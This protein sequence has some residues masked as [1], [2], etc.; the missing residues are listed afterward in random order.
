MAAALAW[1]VLT[2]TPERP[3]AAIDGD[4]FTSQAWRVQL[5]APKNWELT[6][7][8][9][10]PNVLLRMVRHD[11]L[12]RMLLTAERLA[13][14]QDTPS[15]AESTR[16]LLQ[17]LGFAVRPAQLHA[18]TGA[19]WYDF[20]NGTA[21]LR[22]AVLVQNGTGYSL[23]LAAPDARMRGQHLRA[24]DYALRSLRVSRTNVEAPDAGAASSV[25]SD[26]PSS[27][28]EEPAATQ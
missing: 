14:E 4:T 10:Y 17:S 20:D 18:S 27:A 2:L 6:E 15:Y 24:F 12:G 5:T 23:T 16:T 3:R 19:F 1:G 8:G 13:P 7:R 25:G 11:V 9:S 21:F 28:T 26:S 22:Q